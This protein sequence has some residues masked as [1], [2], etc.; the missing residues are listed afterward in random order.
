[1]SG[2]PVRK[3]ARPP[4]PASKK[5]K[6]AVTA[7]GTKKKTPIKRQPVA[8]RIGRQP[9]PKQLFNTLRYVSQTPLTVTLGSA[10]HIFR[11]NGMF[12]PDQTG[13]GHQPLY[14]DTLMAVYQH[15]TVLRSRIKITPMPESALSTSNLLYVIKEDA[16]VTPTVTAYEALEFPYVSSAITPGA[17]G[18]D[19]VSISKTWSAVRTFGGNP[20]SNPDLQGTIASDPTEQSY[21]TLMVRDPVL[22]NGIIDLVVEIEY[23]VVWDELKTIGFS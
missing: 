12:D 4:M 21:F 1:M 17:R 15:Y 5:L 20:Q 11:A 6:L 10:R 3:T 2:V 19:Q 16:D 23:D 8:I 9:F 13:S 18:Q 14:F 22:G 7:N